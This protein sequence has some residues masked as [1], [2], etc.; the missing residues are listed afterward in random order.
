MALTLDNEEAEIL[1]AYRKNSI[2]KVVNEVVIKNNLSLTARNT[3]KK[4]E[5]IQIKLPSQ[6]IHKLKIKAL[7]TGIPIDN[8]ISALVH[9]YLDNKLTLKF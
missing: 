7:E 3:I 2:K 1:K 4:F 9:N 8:I 5:N 6:E